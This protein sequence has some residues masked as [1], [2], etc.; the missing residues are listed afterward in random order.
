VVDA[1]KTAK[2]GSP[3]VW[4]AF[5]AG[6]IAGVGAMLALGGW[7]DRGAE[8]PGDGLDDAVALGESP[9]E[10]TPAPGSSADET[11]TPEQY[12]YA[13]AGRVVDSEGR[14]VAGAAVSARDRQGREHD[15]LSDSGGEFEVRNL[16]LG[17][18][19]LEASATGYSPAVQSGV[20]PDGPPLDLVMQVGPDLVGRVVRDGEG[21][22]RAR[23]AVGGPGLFPPR[24]A[25]TGDDGRFVVS[26]LAGVSPIEL[27]ATADG[28]GSGFGAR[29]IAGDR[30]AVELELREA[31]PWTFRVSDSTT[32]ALVPEGTLSVAGG[33]V[34][35]LSLTQP[36]Q[37]GG[38]VLTGLPPG[39]YHMRVRA[40]GYLP[41][42]GLVEHAGETLEIG[43]EPGRAAHLDNAGGDPPAGVRM[44]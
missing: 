21:V 28:F 17:L 5:A 12:P 7:P 24:T 16:P 32:G 10:P 38:G 18:Y 34:N 15:V 41:W 14:A 36:F 25:V 6:F 11:V 42:E 30:S 9:S 39:A 29:V 13:V 26:D 43:L 22:G 44:E 19:T 20:T 4:L 1:S 37:D 35:V 3:R 2:Q 8:D 33:V 23:V 27:I 40:G 31:P